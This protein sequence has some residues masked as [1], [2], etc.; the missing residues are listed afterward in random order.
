MRSE[1]RQ[2]DAPADGVRR[3][4]AED[5]KAGA[6]QKAV[7]S[8]T[9][10]HPLT[11]IPGASGL[12]VGAFSVVQ[13][14]P[15]GLAVGLGMAFLGT[16]HWAWKFFFRGQQLAQE[17]VEQLRAMR[18][19]AAEQEFIQLEASLEFAGFEDGAKEARELKA[20][21]E[22]LLNV[23]SQHF[24]EDDLTAERFRALAK[25]TFR[26]GAAIL[27]R[28]QKTYEALQS[29]DVD[30]LRRE[31]KAWTKQLAKLDE[32]SP[33][34]AVLRRQIESHEKRIE[35]YGQREQLL[36]ELIAESDGLESALE[37]SSLQVLDLRGRDAS[38]V[39]ESE[40]SA[41]R[42]ERAVEAARRVEERLQGNGETSIGDD[43]A[44]E[45]RA[46]ARKGNS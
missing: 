16:A 17:H 32:H 18:E 26:Q 19:Q 13:L 22:K 9:I 31:H 40:G 7:L 37:S 28:A 10:Q 25:D 34:G 33:N 5:F 23:I 6:V 12:L 30:A 14:S 45:L 21:Y 44:A 46:E 39:F 27:Q 11:L 42:L 2:R 29:L 38:V 3:P 24:A 43:L 20:A 8:K 15:V 36:Q 4:T 1:S 41:T 35:S